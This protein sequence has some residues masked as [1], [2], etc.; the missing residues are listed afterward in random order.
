MDGLTDHEH[1]NL[2]IP[3]LELDL[4]GMC[5]R[6]ALQVSEVDALVHYTEL[7]FSTSGTVID[8]S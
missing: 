7:G 4:Y 5:S 8:L 1:S 6:L 2:L 3:S